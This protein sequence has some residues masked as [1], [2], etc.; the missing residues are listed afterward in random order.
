MFVMWG[1]VAN[2]TVFWSNGKG[3]VH[4][5]KYHLHNVDAYVWGASQK[6]YGSFGT[7]VCLKKKDGHN[8]IIEAHCWAHIVL[9]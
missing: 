8:S 7:H 5:K 3:W 4:T 6:G 9:L 2:N 1:V